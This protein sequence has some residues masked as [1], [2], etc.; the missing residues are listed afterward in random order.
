[1]YIYCN[2]EFNHFF[3]SFFVNPCRI[4]ALN[5]MRSVFSIYRCCRMSSVNVSFFIASH[6]A[7]RSSLFW[8]N[9]Q[10]N[11]PKRWHSTRN[12]TF[13]KMENPSPGGYRILI[14]KH[15]FN[16]NMEMFLPVALDVRFFS[17]SAMIDSTG[18]KI[19][20]YIP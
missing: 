2:F 3:R 16:W 10:T 9:T 14:W 4:R 15:T 19:Q 13:L 5:G 20:C 8:V 6:S 11:C 18:N 1:M 17:V 7:I 12:P